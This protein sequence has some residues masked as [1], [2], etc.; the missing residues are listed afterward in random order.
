MFII[1][2]VNAAPHCSN[3]CKVNF[4]AGASIKTHT[5]GQ[6]MW[7]ADHMKQNFDREYGCFE[8]ISLSTYPVFLSRLFKG[9]PDFLLSE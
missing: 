6:Q 9:L 2:S 7:R 8:F 4:N 3:H 1:Y 5:Q